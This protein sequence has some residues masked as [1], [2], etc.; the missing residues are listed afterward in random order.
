MNYT[1]ELRRTKDF[2]LAHEEVRSK[3]EVSM[4]W[5]GQ[6]YAGGMTIKREWYMMSSTKMERGGSD[7]SKSQF[8]ISIHQLR[9]GE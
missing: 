2:V 1:K 6:L 5:M 9:T 8:R 3:D 4:K 7:D